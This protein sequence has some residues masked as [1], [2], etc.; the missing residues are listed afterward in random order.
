M[1]IRKHLPKAQ[2]PVIVENLIVPT[3]G[4]LKKGR[5]PCGPRPSSTAGYGLFERFVLHRQ[6]HLVAH[7]ELQGVVLEVGIGGAGHDV[8]YDVDHVI[9][10]G[11]I[12]P[13]PLMLGLSFVDEVGIDYCRRS[14]YQLTR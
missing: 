10:G 2:S 11:G 8:R 13:K 6:G 4:A 5:S 3:R 9:D 14:S 12:I 1:Q 7:L